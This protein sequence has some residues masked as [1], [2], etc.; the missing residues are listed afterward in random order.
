VRF[1]QIIR[2]KKWCRFAPS[3]LPERRQHFLKAASGTAGTEI[4]AAELLEKLLVSVNDSFTALH[5]C[6][7]RET[8]ATFAGDFET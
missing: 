1:A 8:F 5:A 2:G 4:V 6:F 7:G 3:N